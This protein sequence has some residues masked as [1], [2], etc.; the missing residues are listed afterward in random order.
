M[1]HIFEALLLESD[2]KHTK[3]LLDFSNVFEKWQRKI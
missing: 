1:V 2:V 3:K